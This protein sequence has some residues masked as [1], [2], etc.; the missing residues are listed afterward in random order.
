MEGVSAVAQSLVADAEK[1]VN[2]SS[3]TGTNESEIQA[4]IESSNESIKKLLS[5]V[6]D[7]KFMVRSTDEDQ[8]NILGLFQDCVTS[9]KDQGMNGNPN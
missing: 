4:V 7:V 6:E 3:T 5:M 2:L 9:L 8:M 1:L